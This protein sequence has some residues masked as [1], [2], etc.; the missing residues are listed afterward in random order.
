MKGKSTLRMLAA[1]LMLALLMPMMPAAPVGAELKST[2]VYL[3]L[4]DSLAEG[5]GATDPA[6]LGYV[7]RL[8]GFF[9]GAPHGNVNSFTNLGFGGESSATFIANGQ[10][11]HALA[12]I[13]DPTTTMGVVTFDIGSNDFLPLLNNADCR[14]DP[15]GPV[16][17]QLI[18]GTLTTLKDNYTSI[19]YSLTGHLAIDPGQ[20]KLLV[21]TYYNPWSGTGDPISK[22]VDMVLFG[23][24]YAQRTI[25]CAANVTDPSRTGVNDI[26]TCVGQYFGATIVDTYPYFDGTSPIFTHI[27][28]GDVHPNNAGYAKIADAFKRAYQGR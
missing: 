15:P 11:A 9:H 22:N 7:P 12:I 2:V 28:E 8:Y 21:M 25:D 20:A 10:L 3:G 13:D 4:G 19:L 17:M 24:D 18:G 14:T 23:S 6:H 16:C 26:L 1:L 5:F 27:L